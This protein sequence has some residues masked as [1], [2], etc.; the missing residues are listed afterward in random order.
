MADK[1]LFD[2]IKTAVVKC[3]NDYSLNTI[4]SSAV[5]FFLTVLFALYNGFLGIILSSLWHTGI[6]VFYM[7]LVVIRGLILAGERKSSQKNDI[8]RQDI[9]H[10]T[11][12]VS[13]IMLLLLNLSLICPIAMMARFEKPVNA[14]LI[15]AIAMAAYTTYKVTASSVHIFKQK[16]I[17]HNDILVSELRIIG[18]IDALVS[19]LT[20][21]NTLIMAENSDSDADMIALSAATSAIVYIVIVIITI[22]LI[23]S[24]IKRVKKKD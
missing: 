1:T 21:Q 5:S 16:R 20:L 22:H 12:I 10:K 17:K 8:D 14:K 13:S 7:L 23:A 15:P 18:F 6:F 24:G 9:R 11:F 19:I 2:K 4:I 3:K